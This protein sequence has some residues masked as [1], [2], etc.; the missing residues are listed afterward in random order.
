[1]GCIVHRFTK[2]RTQLVNFHFTYKMNKQQGPTLQRRELYSI[3]YNNLEKH[4]CVCV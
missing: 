1:M 3:S 2:R 4:V